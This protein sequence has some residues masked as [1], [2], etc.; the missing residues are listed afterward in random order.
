MHS[1]LQMRRYRGSMLR[2]GFG[3][4]RKIGSEFN[5]LEFNSVAYH[6]DSDTA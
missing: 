1:S 6:L 4:R 2:H 5:V 3:F